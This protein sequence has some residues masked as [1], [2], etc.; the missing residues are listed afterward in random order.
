MEGG[1]DEIVEVLPIAGAKEA[2]QDVDVSG[3]TVWPLGKI[4]VVRN[5]LTTTSIGTWEPV[6]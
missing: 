5:A 2:A 6:R 3:K 4:F 1:D